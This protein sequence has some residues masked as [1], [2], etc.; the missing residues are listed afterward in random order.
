M[1]AEP[2]NYSFAICHSPR[3]NKLGWLGQIKRM[4]ETPSKMQLRVIE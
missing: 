1:I 2:I 3:G 4:V